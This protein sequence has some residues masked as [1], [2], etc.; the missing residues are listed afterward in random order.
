MR[1][2]KMPRCCSPAGAVRPPPR[3]ADPLRTQI[4]A[5]EAMVKADRAA[6]RAAEAPVRAARRPLVKALQ[7]AIKSVDHGAR[8]KYAAS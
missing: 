2:V 6:Q 1:A 8:L 7:S 3:T 4:K 5:L